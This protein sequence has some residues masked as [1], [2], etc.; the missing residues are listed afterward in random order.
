MQGSSTSG[1]QLLAPVLSLTLVAV[2]LSSTGVMAA[3]H[4]SDVPTDHPF[5]EEIGWL[6]SEGVTTGFDDGT[7]RPTVAVSRQAAAAF[8]YRLAGEPPVAGVA[9]FSDVP[10]NHRFHDEIAWMVDQEITT[11]YS[12]GTFRPTVAVSRQAIA[13][14]LYRLADEPTVTRQAGFPD[15]PTG[16]PFHDEIAWLVDQQITTGY[17][18]G[19]FRPTVAVSRQAAAAFLHRHTTGT[20]PGPDPDPVPDPAPGD[21]EAPPILLER[22]GSIDTPGAV[23][24][25]SLQLVEGQRVSFEMISF[26]TNMAWRLVGPAPLGTIFDRTNPRGNQLVTAERTGTYTLELYG[27]SPITGTYNFRIHDVTGA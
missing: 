7:F 8:L 25:Y 5:A 19:T 16:H 15:V 18:D 1:R 14:F 23:N 17:S 22:S 2:L 24:A 9:G 20:P 6:V 3:G 12:D 27:S 10:T 26:S 13:A 11:G 4:F 21:C